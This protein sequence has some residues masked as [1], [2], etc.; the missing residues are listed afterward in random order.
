MYIFVEGFCSIVADDASEEKIVNGEELGWRAYTD[1]RP[2]EIRASS[3]CGLIKIEAQA[4]TA[5][6][7]ATPQLNYHTRKRLAIEGDDRV[8]WLLGVVATY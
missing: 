3:D 4:Y 8:D 5:L 6:L 1:N 2:V 7:K